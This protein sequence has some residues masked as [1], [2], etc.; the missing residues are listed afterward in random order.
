MLFLPK[1][2]QYSKQ[3]I[4]III[5]LSMKS[6]SMLAELNLTNSGDMNEADA[7]ES[8]VTVFYTTL[9]IGRMSIILRSF[10]NDILGRLPKLNK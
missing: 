10:G 2:N 6:A 8:A 3:L 9:L 5:I 1:T 7:F 4:I